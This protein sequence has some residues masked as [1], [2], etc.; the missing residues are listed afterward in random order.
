MRAWSALE[1]NWTKSRRWNKTYDAAFRALGYIPCL[2]DFGIYH[3]IL[4]VDGEFFITI[5]AIH[6]NNSI[7]VTSRNH[8]S[9]AIAEP[10]R[11]FEMR[12]LSELRHVLGVNFERMRK[13]SILVARCTA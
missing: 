12:S 10:Q 2:T 3:R 8:T 13:P 4:E 11:T 6:V 7:V 1:A 9:F 5:I